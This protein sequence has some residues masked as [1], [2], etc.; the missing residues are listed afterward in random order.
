PVSRPG[1]HRALAGEG[2]GPIRR[3]R[4]PP[5]RGVTVGPCLHTCRAVGPADAPVVSPFDSPAHGCGGNDA[6]PGHRDPCCA[7]AGPR[8]QRLQVAATTG[9]Q[10]LSS[11]K[12]PPQTPVL[13]VGAG[14]AG[15][16]VARELADA[17]RRVLVIDKRPH[18][19]GN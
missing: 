19:A 11:P 10:R 14:Y 9:T 7:E 8:V 18:I 6:V 4:S 3:R 16:V 15:S 2:R 13:V 5:G 1:G 17:G 12:P